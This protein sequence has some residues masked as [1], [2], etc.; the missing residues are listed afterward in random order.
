[1]FGALGVQ[2]ERLLRIQD[3]TYFWC[4]ANSGPNTLR[5]QDETY[6]WK[7]ANSGR[8]AP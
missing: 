2:E 4:L 6:F 5:I 1:M 7:L 8:N 3:E